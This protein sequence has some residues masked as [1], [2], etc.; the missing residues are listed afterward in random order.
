MQRGMGRARSLETRQASAKWTRAADRLLGAQ[1]ARTRA[2]RARAEGRASQSLGRSQRRRD[3]GRG[4]GRW[5][6]W[7]VQ[8]A[9]I[10]RVRFCAGFSA[11]WRQSPS[12]LHLP[13][14][15]QL[16]ACTA[17]AASTTPHAAQQPP[18][19]PSLRCACARLLAEAR[20][21]IRGVCAH[22]CSPYG[23]IALFVRT[24]T[25]PAYLH[26]THASRPRRWPSCSMGEL[27]YIG[28][29]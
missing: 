24:P 19:V 8:M 15:H 25:A 22:P 10:P 7:Q 4:G 5:K 21:G 13:I 12:T 29:N 3:G 1:R 9:L 16:C 11:A 20:R 27:R 18:A 23:I 14:S 2:R 26:A 6:R 17:P 28:D